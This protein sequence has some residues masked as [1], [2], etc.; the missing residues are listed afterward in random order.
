MNDNII[1]TI[2]NGKLTDAIYV[3]FEKTWNIFI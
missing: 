2:N 1:K 3:Y